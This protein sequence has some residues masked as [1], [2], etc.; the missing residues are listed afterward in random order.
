MNE[1][2]RTITLKD[3]EYKVFPKFVNAIKMVPKAQPQSAEK[4]K[5]YLYCKHI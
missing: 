3:F 4:Q 1:E 5:K 2:S